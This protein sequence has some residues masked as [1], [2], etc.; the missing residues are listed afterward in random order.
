[1]VF[2]TPAR[3]ARRERSRVSYARTPYETLG[4]LY[5]PARGVPGNA[6]IPETSTRSEAKILGNPGRLMVIP[7]KSWLGA[8][9]RRMHA[10]IN[11]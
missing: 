10:W 4:F 11:F 6:D 9:R 3:E 7:R 1:M 2:H 8:R 5:I